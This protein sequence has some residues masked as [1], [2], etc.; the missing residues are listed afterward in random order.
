MPAPPVG[1]ADG[2]TLGV[3]GR[4]SVGV[5][6]GVALGVGV[7]DGVGDGEGVCET[8]TKAAAGMGSTTLAADA[9]APKV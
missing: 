3:G 2:E 4:L 5:A 1:D 8:D 9:T 6:L 7:G